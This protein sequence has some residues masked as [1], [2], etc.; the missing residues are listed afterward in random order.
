MATKLGDVVGLFKEYL[1]NKRKEKMDEEKLA[2]YGMSLQQENLKSELDLLKYDMA[3]ARESK[4]KVK[5]EYDAAQEKWEQLTDKPI[6]N[7]FKTE[8][9]NVLK[10]NTTGTIKEKYQN[11]IQGLDTYTQDLLGKTKSMTNQIK[12]IDAVK[13]F[14]LHA[15]PAQSKASIL[16]G[17]GKEGEEGF[18]PEAQLYDPGDFTWEAWKAQNKTHFESQDEATQRLMEDVFEKQYTAGSIQ[19]LVDE[20]NVP[21]IQARNVKIDAMNKVEED[22]R[23][24]KIQDLNFKI[25]EQKYGDSLKKDLDAEAQ[26]NWAEV[27]GSITP[28][29]DYEFDWYSADFFMDAEGNPLFNQEDHQGLIR[30]LNTALNMPNAKDAITLFD[31]YDT[32]AGGALTEW[33]EQIG[34]SPGPI[35]GAIYENFKMMQDKV[36]KS[37]LQTPAW[38]E[39]KTDHILKL[40]ETHSD[41]M[42]KM[43]EEFAIV[44][45]GAGMDPK[46]VAA[47]EEGLK[48]N[49]N[50][51]QLEEWDKVKSGKLSEIDLDEGDDEGDDDD[52]DEDK[53]WMDIQKKYSDVLEDSR[54]GGVPLETQENVKRGLESQ[55]ANIYSGLVDEKILKDE[56]DNKQSILNDLIQDRDILAASYNIDWEELLN[57]VDIPVPSSSNPF[58]DRTVY[59]RTYA[60]LSDV[61]KAVYDRTTVIR[62][63]QNKLDNQLKSLNKITADLEGKQ[64]TFN[65]ALDRILEA[66]K[67]LD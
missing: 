26:A 14:A 11:R 38:T 43:F 52:L 24:K 35:A 55:R 7:E 50:E 30:A 28:A 21:T 6:P 20:L 10:E 41:D 66:N 19:K 59:A 8:G 49:F 51:N 25:T 64:D 48:T 56:V 3:T 67:A 27:K 40:Y 62:V 9:F 1:S 33:M 13:E 2:L 60:G 44:T 54:Y 63:E 31:E 53:N 47:L 36:N 42:S 23:K 17:V 57:T 12:A 39:E 34:N 37:N 65:K 46:D 16:P 61:E 15:D 58:I 45:M 5:G 32:E 18:L 22:Q 4:N 29:E